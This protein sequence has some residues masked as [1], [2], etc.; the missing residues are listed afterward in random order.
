[1]GRQS[2]IGRKIKKKEEEALM[3]VK[4]ETLKEEKDHG[5][6]IFPIRLEGKLNENAL[7][8]TDSVINTMP[9]RIYA[10]LGRDD[11]QKLTKES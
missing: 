4:G 3:K 8:D 2:E 10:E 1:M 6:F 9:Y 5:A 11:I 7:A